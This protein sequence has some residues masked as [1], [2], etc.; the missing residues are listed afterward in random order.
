MECLL[1]LL[2]SARTITEIV[3]VCGKREVYYL[4]F[5]VSEGI[6]VKKGKY[7]LLLK[8]YPYVF[9]KVNVIVKG[10]EALVTTIGY[11]LKEGAKPWE[12][13]SLILNSYT[14]RLS[15]VAISNNNESTFKLVKE[16]LVNRDITFTTVELKAP[17]YK[18][19]VMLDKEMIPYET[20]AV[21]IIPIG[22]KPLSNR[23][24]KE[25]KWVYVRPNV[26]GFI[27]ID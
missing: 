6:V 10:D 20:R 11:P 4:D 22:G 23:P 26:Y 1:N 17:A 15:E 9:K 5:L 13:I 3:S 21:S 24:L 14:T 7:Y 8:N 27:K 12:F 2:T 25:Y 16:S 19:K 18:L